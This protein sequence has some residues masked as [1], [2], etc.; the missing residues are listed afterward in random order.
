MEDAEIVL[1]FSLLAIPVAIWLQLWVKDRREKRRNTLGEE[2][3]ESTSRAF[4][5]IV[6]EGTAIIGGLIMI[7][8]AT[9]G[10]G[11]YILNFYL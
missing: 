5:S 2:E 4:V 11:K 6:I 7:I 3:F 10:V 9:S 8:M 1:M